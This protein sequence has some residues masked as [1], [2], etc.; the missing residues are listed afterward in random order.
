MIDDL[1]KYLERL[2][3]QFS[4]EH[5]ERLTEADEGKLAMGTMQH[6]DQVVVAFGKPV[7]WF[8]LGPNEALQ[9]ADSI[10]RKASAILSGKE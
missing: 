2:Q 3:E 9:L 10:G 5:Y 1:V 4:K 6:E 7:T 8:A